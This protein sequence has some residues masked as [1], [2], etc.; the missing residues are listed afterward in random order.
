MIHTVQEEGKGKKHIIS[1]FKKWKCAK[2]KSKS[3]EMKHM[4]KNHNSTDTEKSCTSN[5]EL[6]MIKE[7]ENRKKMEKVQNK[8]KA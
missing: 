4:K 8:S 1:F 5:G 3:N 2:F 7:L 6:L